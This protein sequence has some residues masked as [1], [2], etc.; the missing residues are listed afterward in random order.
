MTFP[1]MRT[2]D[3]TA[4]YIREKDPDTAFT[5]TALRRLIVSGEIPSRKVGTKYLVSLETVTEY[6]TGVAGDSATEEHRQTG[7]IRPVP[8]Q[9]MAKHSYSSHP[10]PSN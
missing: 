6:L 3:Q 2:I 7:K 5:K 8:I 9:P 10:S 4:A 1:T